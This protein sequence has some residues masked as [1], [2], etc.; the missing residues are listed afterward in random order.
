MAREDRPVIYVTDPDVVEARLVHPAAHRARMAHR[1]IRLR[2]L[3]FDGE[4]LRDLS[5]VDG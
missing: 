5:S 4:N 1:V 3:G 2:E